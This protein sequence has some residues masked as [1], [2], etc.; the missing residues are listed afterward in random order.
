MS[1]QLPLP[2][3]PDDVD[4]RLQHFRLSH[5]SQMI[6]DGKLNLSDGN[7]LR[8]GKWSEKQKSLFIESLMIKLP[9]PVFYFDGSQS[10]WLVI[11]GLKRLIAIKDFISGK[12]RLSNLEYLITECKGL[13][14]NELPSYLQHRIMEADFIAYIINPGTPV[15]VKYNIIKRINATVTPL[16]K[17]IIRNMFYRDAASYIREWADAPIVGEVTGNNLSEAN[18]R[19]YIAAYI[20]FFLLK[21]DYDGDMDDFLNKGMGALEALYDDAR[22]KAKARFILSLERA[23]RLFGKFAFCIPKPDGW[24]RK[25]S[26]HLFIACTWIMNLLSEEEFELLLSSNEFREEYRDS[27]LNGNLSKTL[28]RPYSEGSVQERFKILQQLI[29]KYTKR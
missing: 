10:P 8:Y 16:K 11:D 9:I 24:N 19:E 5:L 7:R 12:Y 15:E 18:R 3:N 13:F 6:E 26:I 4:V 14:F 20:S 2:Y 17:Q 1:Y 21:L 23:E 27:A 25:P 22:E 28:K 29:E